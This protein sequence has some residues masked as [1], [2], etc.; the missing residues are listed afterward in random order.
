MKKKKTDVSLIRYLVTHTDYSRRALMQLMQ[1][2][3][4]H[5]AAYDMGNRV[6]YVS[7]GMTDSKGQFL[8]Y[9]YEAP[10]IAFDMD[11]LWDEKRS[12]E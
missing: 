11:M 2:G 3:D 12:V 10:F 4:V 8:R 1:S 7:R 5:V 9:A 6:A